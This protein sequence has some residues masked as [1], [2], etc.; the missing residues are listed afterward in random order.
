VSGEN[1]D[2]VKRIRNELPEHAKHL[3]DTE[4]H[5]VIQLTSKTSQVPSTLEDQ[6]G[7]HPEAV[8]KRLRKQIKK[9]V[10]DLVREHGWC[11]RIDHRTVNGMLNNWTDCK[12]QADA[13]IAGLEDRLGLVRRWLNS[14]SELHQAQKVRREAARR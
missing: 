10:N 2:Q 14:K 3:A 5:L 9:V 13:D 12:S 4:I 11:C 8:G 7:D 1:L 6:Q